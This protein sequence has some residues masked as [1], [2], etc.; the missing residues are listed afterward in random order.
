MKKFRSFWFLGLFVMVFLGSIVML[1]SSGQEAT[2]GPEPKFECV[3]IP[4]QIQDRVKKELYVTNQLLLATIEMV[5]GMSDDQIEHLKPIIK[6]AFSR[7]YL[8]KPKFTQER[9]KPIEGWDYILPL[10]QKMKRNMS[11]KAI[12]ITAIVV[13]GE[14]LAYDLERTPPLEGDDDLIL[15]IRT[16]IDL[17]S[18]DEFG[19]DLRHRRLCELY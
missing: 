19:G 12:P 8:K 7:T 5:P 9:G 1:N 6:L 15:H 2:R 3:K 16:I 10:L 4:L 14:F 17:G 13:T 18:A 11:G